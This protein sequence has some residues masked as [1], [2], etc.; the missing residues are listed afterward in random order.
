MLGLVVIVTLL[1]HLGHCQVSQGSLERQN[2]GEEP[3]FHSISLVSKLYITR[4]KIPVAAV[5]IF[6]SS[7]FSL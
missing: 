3:L 1:A 5:A 2:D 6:L 7:F 4:Q